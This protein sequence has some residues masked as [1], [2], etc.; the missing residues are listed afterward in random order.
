[1]DQHQ[2]MMLDRYIT[3]NYG[4]DSI[5]K[6]KCPHDPEIECEQWNDCEWGCRYGDDWCVHHPSYTRTKGTVAITPSAWEWVCPLCDEVRATQVEKG[7]V[8]C[9]VC[10]EVFDVE[11][12]DLCDTLGG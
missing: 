7:E 8:E 4:E 10:C 9:S 3:G 1:M 6:G 12:P 11:V 5:D 2:R